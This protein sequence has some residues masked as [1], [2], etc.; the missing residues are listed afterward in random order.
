MSNS[1]FT[2]L[3]SKTKIG[4]IANDSFLQVFGWH[5]P[6]ELKAAVLVPG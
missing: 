2:N 3:A 4:Y 6:T 1:A 5:K